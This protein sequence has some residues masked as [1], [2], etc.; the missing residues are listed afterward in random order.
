LVSFTPQLLYPRGNRPG[1]H[2]IWCCVGPRTGLD[3]VESRKILPLP[4]LEL[5]PFGRAARGQSLYRLKIW[6]IFIIVRPLFWGRSG[7]G[8]NKSELEEQSVRS[9]VVSF[10]W[11]QT[12][13][14]GALLSTSSC[15]SWSHLS[16]SSLQWSEVLLWAALQHK[17]SLV[18]ICH[19]NE[20]AS[21]WDAYTDGFVVIGK[22]IHPFIHQWPYIRLLGPGLYF[23]FVIIFTQTVGLL[24]RG[25]SP[26]QGLYLHTGQHKH[27]INTHKNIHVLSGIRTH[28]SRVWAGEDSSCLRPRGHRDRLLENYWIIYF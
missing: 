23:S 22:F 8:S 14:R 25:I 1:T 16:N 19:G 21:L 18:F 9:Q 5:R 27:R 28:Y 10:L 2:W 13:E 17:S 3:D 15:I 12:I 11:T 26:S 4:G 24:G 7:L 20:V 6:R